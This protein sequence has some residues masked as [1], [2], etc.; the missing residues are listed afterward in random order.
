MAKAVV[1]TV[2]RRSVRLAVNTPGGNAYEAVNTWRRSARQI[3]WRK[4]PVNH[5]LNALH[6][7]GPEASGPPIGE[8]KASWRTD[9][10]GTNGSFVR[11]SLKNIAPH[12]DI[13]EEGRSPSA[14]DQVFSWVKWGGQIRRVTRTRGRAG[15]HICLI[16]AMEAKRRWL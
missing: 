12:A 9:M 3:A 15:Q 14:K 16:A 2:S 8:Y 10:K 13:V 7:W 1:N 5:V 4:S 6:R 11:A